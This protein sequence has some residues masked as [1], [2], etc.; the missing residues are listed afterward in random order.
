[1]HFARRL[2]LLLDFTI[3]HYTNNKQSLDDV[4]RKLYNRFYKDQ[5]RGFTEKELRHTCEIVAGVKLDELFDYVYTTKALNYTKYFNYGGLD[6][7]TS[8]DSFIIKPVQQPD[9]LQASILKSWLS[10]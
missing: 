7:D 10:E 5:D 8:S 2:M 6:I 3:R 9:A 1:M 4:I